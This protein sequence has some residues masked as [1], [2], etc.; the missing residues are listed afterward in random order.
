MG[1]LLTARA[2]SMTQGNATKAA[3]LTGITR[4]S[5]HKIKSMARIMQRNRLRSG[6]NYNCCSTARKFGGFYET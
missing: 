6:I 4:S 3:E 2:L 5:F 1:Q